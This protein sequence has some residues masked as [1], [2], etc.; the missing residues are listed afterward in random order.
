MALETLKGVE[1]IGGHQVATM[2]INHSMCETYPV[3]IDHKENIVLFKIQNGPIKEHGV[4]GCQV[5]TLIHAA[6]I[7]L[8][9]L[10]AKFP[11][12]YNRAAIFHL[13]DAIS[14]LDARTK[15]REKR[16]V[17]GYDKD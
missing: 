5:D 16:G 14:E 13:G 15:D 10:N 7:M 9:G 8:R 11:S 3:G 6:L 1:K 4:N 12:S 17:E 2:G